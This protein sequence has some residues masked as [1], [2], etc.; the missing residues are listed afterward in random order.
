MEFPMFTGVAQ[1]KDEWIVGN[2]VFNKKGLF[3]VNENNESIE[4][5]A[6]TVSQLIPM[7]PR[8]K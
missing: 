1:D 6:D 3:I 2:I 4:V 7:F 5:I 8:K